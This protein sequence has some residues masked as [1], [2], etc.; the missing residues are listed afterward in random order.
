[1]TNLKLLT[2]EAD[3]QRV[4]EGFIVPY[5]YVQIVEEE[6]KDEVKEL[7][8]QATDEGIIQSDYE[9]VAE[10][11]KAYLSQTNPCDL[12][13]TFIGYVLFFYPKVELLKDCFLRYLEDEDPI[14]MTFHKMLAVLINI[15]GL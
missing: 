6:D 8:L 7:V 11:Y 13:I 10:F 5:C 9:C 14:E 15:D 4:F 2:T 3:I 1:M 12:D